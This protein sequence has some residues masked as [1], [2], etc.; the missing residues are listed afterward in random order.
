MCSPRT[1]RNKSEHQDAFQKNASRENY[2]VRDTLPG[3]AHGDACIFSRRS[4]QPVLSRCNLQKSSHQTDESFVNLIKIGP[5]LI[6]R[7]F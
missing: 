6:K 5:S 4:N 7:G 1:K 2:V 3:C